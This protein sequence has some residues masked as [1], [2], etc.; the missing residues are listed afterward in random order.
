MS[1]DTITLEVSGT[2]SKLDALLELLAPTGIMELIRT[3][4][5]AIP[6]AKRS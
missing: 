2:Q 4:A 3:G 6:R 5:I 1:H